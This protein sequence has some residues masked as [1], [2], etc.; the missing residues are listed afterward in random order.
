MVRMKLNIFPVVLLMLHRLGFDWQT[1][2]EVWNVAM[3]TAAVLPLVGWIRRQFDQ[4]V[5]YAAGFLYATH[6]RLIE[7]SPEVIRDPTFWFLFLLTIYCS[8]RRSARSNWLVSCS[9]E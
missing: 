5:A 1:A 8:S 4:R 9:W 3:S 2:G 7:R 6:A